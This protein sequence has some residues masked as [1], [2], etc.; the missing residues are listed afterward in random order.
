MIVTSFQVLLGFVNKISSIIQN[1]QQQ[2]MTR[3]RICNCCS[4]QCHVNDQWL[5]VAH[6]QTVLCPGAQRNML[7]RPLTPDDCLIVSKRLQMFALS[8]YELLFE[9]LKSQFHAKYFDL[10][11]FLQTKYPHSVRPGLSEH[12]LI[13]YSVQVSML[14]L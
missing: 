8:V 13:G 10:K 6:A 5:A 2:Q 7:P 11:H 3:S 14:Q 9:C 1:S 12:I 4:W